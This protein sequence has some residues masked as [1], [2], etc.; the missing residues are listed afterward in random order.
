M[1]RCPYCRSTLLQREYEGDIT[2]LACSRTVSL[3]PVDLPSARS[4]QVRQ[5]LAAWFPEPEETRRCGGCG[6]NRPISDFRKLSRSSYADACKACTTGEI[7][8]QMRKT[9]GPNLLRR[10]AAEARR[11]G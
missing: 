10:V 4:Q 6:E 7:P 11:A 5:R 9:S 1:A 8:P 3:V 2:C